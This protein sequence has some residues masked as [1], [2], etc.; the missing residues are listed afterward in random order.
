MTDKDKNEE[1]N[2]FEELDSEEFNNEAPVTET[3]APPSTS[4]SLTPDDIGGM[5]YIKNP[6]VGTSVEFII[7][8]VNK[9]PSRTLK[10]STDG[11]EFETG[12]KK[13]N[14]ERH[15]INIIT[16]EGKCFS[17]ATWGLFFALFGKKSKIQAK[18][19]EKGNTYK[20]LKVK[21]TH[22]FNGKDS[23]SSLKDIMALRGIKTEKEA[24]V[25]KEKVAQAIKDGT[26]YKA[27]LV[28]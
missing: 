13:K 8:E 25:H 11:S 18:A 23:K 16:D 22:I 4:Q 1:K 9:D 21:I 6:E 15:E 5:E 17:V 28:D 26:I 10:N 19:K 27:E 7:G 3:P 14:G 24:Q 2:E 20:D 12:L